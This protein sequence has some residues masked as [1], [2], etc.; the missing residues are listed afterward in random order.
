[1]NKSNDKPDWMSRLYETSMMR[2]DSDADSR[3]LFIARCIMIDIFDFSTYGGGG[4]SIIA[5]NA[6]NIIAIITE[7]G[8]VLHNDQRSRLIDCLTNMQTYADMSTNQFCEF[9]S[10]K[11]V[12]FYHIMIR[13]LTQPSNTDILRV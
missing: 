3:N 9:L 10:R 8:L 6:Y 4:H 2:I 11:L 1:M 13:Q 12:T 5:R 7:H